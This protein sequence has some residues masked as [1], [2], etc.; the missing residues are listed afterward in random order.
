M[1]CYTVSA[2]WMCLCAL[3]SALQCHKF[4]SSTLDEFFLC[5]V[6]LDLSHVLSGFL[7]QSQNFRKIGYRLGHR[8]SSSSPISSRKSIDRQLLKNQ[9]EYFCFLQLFQG[10]Y[11]LRINRSISSLCPSCHPLEAVHQRYTCVFSC[12]ILHPFIVS[13]MPSAGYNV[14]INKEVLINNSKRCPLCPQA[15]FS[16]ALRSYQC[17]RLRMNLCRWV[18]LLFLWLRGW[19]YHGTASMLVCCHIPTWD[20]IRSSFSGEFR[21]NRAGDSLSCLLCEQWACL[22]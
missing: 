13:C 22:H 6:Y 15:I 2:D 11:A 8:R 17:G 1:K 20:E 14:K 18:I 16:T 9:K 19:T 3:P 12:Y 10:G 5:Y 21:D 4:S 7:I